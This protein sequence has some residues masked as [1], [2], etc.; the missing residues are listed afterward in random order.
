MIDALARQILGR[1]AALQ[2]ELSDPVVIADR[3]RFTAAS[4][5]YSELEPAAKLATEYLRTLD[6]LEGAREL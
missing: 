1:F 3:E 2:E 5:A 6:D 4:R